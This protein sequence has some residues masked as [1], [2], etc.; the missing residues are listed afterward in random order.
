MFFIFRTTFVFSYSSRLN[1]Q[2]TDWNVESRMLNDLFEL[3]MKRGIIFT[4]KEFV[5]RYNLLKLVKSISFI[6]VYSLLKSVIPYKGFPMK[7]MHTYDI[8]NC[9]F[10]Y[11]DIFWCGCIKCSH[12]SIIDREKHELLTV[13]VRP[14]SLWA[15]IYGILRKNIRITLLSNGNDSACSK[16]TIKITK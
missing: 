2:E 11:N 1:I 10:V 12:C 3:N 6:P 15:K 8:N 16:I 7:E 5:C 9:L 13:I 14:F 4:C